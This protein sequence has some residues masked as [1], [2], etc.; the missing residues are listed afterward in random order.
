MYAAKAAH[1]LKGLNFDA[2]RVIVMNAVDRVVASQSDLL[3]SGY[4][5]VTNYVE[6]KT[7]DRHCGAP[8]RGEVNTF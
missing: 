2:K 6:Y 3:V 8:E 5:P 4:I 7:S 1:A